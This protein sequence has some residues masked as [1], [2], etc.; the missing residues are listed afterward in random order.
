MEDQDS[1]P[2]MASLQRVTKEVTAVVLDCWK[3]I[4]P[5]DVFQAIQDR[6]N[7]ACCVCSISP[8][9]GICVM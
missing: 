7:S 2:A 3:E 4:Y 6:H 5:L 9:A 8:E 1:L